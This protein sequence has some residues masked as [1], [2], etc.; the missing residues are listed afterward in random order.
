MSKRKKISKEL[1]KEI[2]Y[3]SAR[4]CCLC[5]GLNGDFKIKRGQ[6]AHINRDSNNNSFENLVFLCFEHHDLYD[7]TTSQSKG[8]TEAELTVYRD[9][10]YTDVEKELPRLENQWKRFTDNTYSF[11]QFINSLRNNSLFNSSFLNDYEIKK[12]VEQGHLNI[13][14]FDNNNVSCA[15]YNFTLGEEAM[16]NNKHLKLSKSHPLKISRDSFALVI[17][18]EIIGIPIGL[19]GRICPIISL[20]RLGINLFYSTHIDS[21]FIGRIVV[22]VQNNS[23][24]DI[25]I[26]PGYKIFSVEFCLLNIPEKNIK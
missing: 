16:I 19:F 7:S 23:M 13:E 15:G 2:L 22:S 21:G 4:R 6:I 8:Y 18:K 25:V 11:H 10:L 1:E 24:E 3:K 5:Y 20:E 26:S 14:P 12:S 17:S 9:I